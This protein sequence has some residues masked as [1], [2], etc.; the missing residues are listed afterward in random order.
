VSCAG[1][2]LT[3]VYGEGTWYT[4]SRTPVSAEFQTL[5]ESVYP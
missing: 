2:D 5:F 4:E 3:D 1:E